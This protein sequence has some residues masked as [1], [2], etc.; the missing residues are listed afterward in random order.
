MKQNICLKITALLLILIMVSTSLSSCM[1]NRHTVGSGAQ[2]GV[3]EKSRQ[4]YALWGLVKLGDSD[5]KNMVGDSTD[6]KVETYYGVADWFINFFLG[7]LSIKS[8]TI[9]V[10]K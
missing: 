1:T 2:T 10:T 9:K 6:Y 4:W 5:T 7:W 8:R 3:V